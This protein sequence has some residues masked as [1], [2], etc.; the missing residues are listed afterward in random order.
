MLYVMKMTRENCVACGDG[1]NDITM[2]KFAGV[3]VAMANAQP[4]VKAASDYVTYSNDEDGLVH[5]IDK[6]FK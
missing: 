1:F 6:Y 4:A 2:I 5:V 3:G